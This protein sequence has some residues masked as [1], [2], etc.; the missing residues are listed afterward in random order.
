MKPFHSAYV[1]LFI[2]CVI[3]FKGVA[4]ENNYWINQI[5]AKSSLLSGAVTAS[6]SD[7]SAVYYNPGNLAYISKSNI[8][9]ST[10]IYTLQGLF[11]K[12][13]AGN[14]INLS[15]TW[16]GISPSFFSGGFKIKGT[17]F[18]AVTYAV[19]NTIN[20]RYNLKGTHQGYHDIF[21]S[22]P[23][24]EYY[25][26]GYDYRIEI[27]EDWIGMGFGTE[28]KTGLSIGL[29]TFFTIRQHRNIQHTN[30]STFFE[31]RR[32]GSFTQIG[33]YTDYRELDQIHVGNLWK[34]GIAYRKD[35]IK[36]GLSITTPRWTIP[37]VSKSVIERKLE[38]SESGTNSTNVSLY[39][40]KLDSYYKSPTIFDF[41]LEFPISNN[42]IN[43]RAA[44]F[45]AVDNY[46][47]V[48]VRTPETS[49]GQQNG[50]IG[51]EFQEVWTSNRAVF[52]IGMG[53]EH[54]V[55]DRLYGIAGFRTDFNHYDN[56]TQRMPEQWIPHMSYWNLYHFSG[57]IHWYTRKFDE[58]ILGL[59]YAYGRSKGDLQLASINNPD[60][61]NNMMGPIGTDTETRYNRLSLVI[62]LTL[63][64]APK[65]SDQIN[66]GD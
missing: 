29:S 22:F 53:F 66:P 7:N 43:F 33:N 15:R 46:K 28:I 40:E 63:N 51:S 35:K 37:L 14:G 4:Q 27:R 17:P 8:N 23:G 32:N 56:Q 9:L 48:E 31:N 50:N 61:N 11:I 21:P 60:L 19:F 54:K 58:I 42:I 18:S 26:S 12:N 30:S 65:T 45:T 16:L 24:K 10:D 34:I 20:T 3:Q 55:N 49:L 41:G 5:G 38:Y 57:G 25:N 1:L 39:Q 6:A 2:F 52:N 36:A 64:F 47:M 44:W 13:G 62:G 59:N